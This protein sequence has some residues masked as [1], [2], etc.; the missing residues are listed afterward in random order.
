[1]KE[2]LPLV[3]TNLRIKCSIIFGE[4]KKKITKKILSI[5]FF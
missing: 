1:M 3:K 2:L 4:D 5:V